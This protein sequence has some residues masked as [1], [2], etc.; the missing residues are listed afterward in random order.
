MT[1]LPEKARRLALILGSVLVAGPLVT[2]PTSAARLCPQ[3]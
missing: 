3:S 1:T 2:V